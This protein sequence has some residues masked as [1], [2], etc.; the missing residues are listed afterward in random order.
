MPKYIKFIYVYYVLLIDLFTFWWNHILKR[1]EKLIFKE[2]IHNFVFFLKIFTQENIILGSKWRISFTRTC[3]Q[4][5]W[6]VLN[7]YLKTLSFLSI[8]YFIE[9]KNYCFGKRYKFK[10]GIHIFMLCFISVNKDFILYIV[11]WWPLNILAFNKTL[12]NVFLYVK[13]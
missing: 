6:C 11:Q 2:Y 5:E 1:I 10:F 8:H 13:L 7:I 3:V 12:N 4:E 9:R